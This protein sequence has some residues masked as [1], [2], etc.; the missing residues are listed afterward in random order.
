M[1]ETGGVQQIDAIDAEQRLQTGALLLDVREPDEWQAGH[2]PVALHVPMGE[3]TQRD[4]LPR[5]RDIVVV[6]RSGGRSQRVAQFLQANGLRALNLD[7]GM[8]AW[9]AS[10]LDVVTDNGDQGTI[11]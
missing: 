7:G 11:I 3:I 10:G 5:D 1:T 2:A 4:D 9:V 8:R 6:C